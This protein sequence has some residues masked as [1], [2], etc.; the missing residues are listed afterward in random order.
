MKIKVKVHS[1]SSQEKIIKI[2]EKEFEIWLK[3]KPIY[4]RANDKIEKILKKE[5]GFK[6]KILSGFNS[7]IK[8]V[9]VGD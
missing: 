4:G 8:F 9:E 5:F 7:K 1:N 3:E 6:I 2:S